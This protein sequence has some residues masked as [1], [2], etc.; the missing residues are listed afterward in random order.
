MG[1]RSRDDSD[2]EEEGPTKRFRHQNCTSAQPRAIIKVYVDG[3][4]WK[5]EN[6]ER[7]KNMHCKCKRRAGYGIYFPESKRKNKRYYGRCPQKVQKSSDAEFYA[8]TQ[9]IRWFRTNDTRLH[10]FTDCLTAVNVSKQYQVWLNEQ[11]KRKVH[12]E[13]L[14]EEMQ[15]CKY[16]PKLSFVRGHSGDAGNNKADKLARKGMRKGCEGKCV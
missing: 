10:I 2:D 8:I 13:T 16:L 3:S 11:H 15:S 14:F 1:K 12:V 6:G 7:T 4:F 9:A 5:K